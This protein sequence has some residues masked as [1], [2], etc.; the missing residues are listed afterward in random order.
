MKLFSRLRVSIH[1]NK[2]TWNINGDEVTHTV[3]CNHEEAGTQMVLSAALSSEDVV[4]VAS[5]TDVLIL[6]SHAYSEYM[7]KMPWI[8]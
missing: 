8:Y 6:M 2:N 4:A 1:D 5:D 7:V 3:E